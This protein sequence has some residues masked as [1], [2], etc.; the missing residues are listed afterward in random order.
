M[1]RVE[2]INDIILTA[3]TAIKYNKDSVIEKL[4]QK[5]QTVSGNYTS[6]LRV[7]DMFLKND[8]QEDAI[9]VF[10][11]MISNVTKRTYQFSD[12]LL[13]LTEIALQRDLL[14]QAVNAISK[15]SMYL[16]T[17]K[18]ELVVSLKSDLQSAKGLPDTDKITLPLFYGC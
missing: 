6:I 16:G 10:S 11:E 8:R 7:V 14:E 9:L 17:K 13:F 3:E 12:K 5:V 4:V 2:N 18:Y 15:L 1:N